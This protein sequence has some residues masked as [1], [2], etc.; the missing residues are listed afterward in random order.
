MHLLG[1]DPSNFVRIPW[2]LACSTLQ[3]EN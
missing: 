1:R 2:H 3:V